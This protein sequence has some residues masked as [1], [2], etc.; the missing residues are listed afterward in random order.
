MGLDSWGGVVVHA[1]SEA[2]SEGS[3]REVTVLRQSWLASHSIMCVWRDL[4]RAHVCVGRILGSGLDVYG[5]WLLARTVRGHSHSPGTV[6]HHSGTQHHSGHSWQPSSMPIS[7]CDTFR[8]RFTKPHCTSLAHPY[9]RSPIL[10]ELSCMTSSEKSA[11]W[12]LV[13]SHA[14]LVLRNQAR[15][16]SALGSDWYLALLWAGRSAQRGSVGAGAC[17]VDKSMHSF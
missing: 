14:W 1:S 4:C 10:S 12:R 11:P 6:F 3:H 16:G 17:S 7:H 9:S 2:R 5:C 15:L 8:P 13:F